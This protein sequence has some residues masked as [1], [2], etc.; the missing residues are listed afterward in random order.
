MLPFAIIMVLRPGALNVSKE[1]V[2]MSW[3]VFGGLGVGMVSQNYNQVLFM[4][5]LANKYFDKL[6]DE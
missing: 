3:G 5:Q 4:R 6:S 2:L 1:A